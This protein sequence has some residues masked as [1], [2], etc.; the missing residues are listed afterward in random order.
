MSWAPPV[1]SGFGNNG[2][3]SIAG[4]APR[5]GEDPVV[6]SNFV[7]PGYFQT[8]GQRLLAGRDFTDR[9]RRGAPRVAIINQSMA[10]YFFGEESP[11]GH[12][13]A[14]W[15]GKTSPPDCEI[16]GIVA[17]A[18]HFDLKEPPKRVVYVPYD[19]GPDF[20]Q[21]ENMVL[22]V[23]ST[24]PPAL[25]T[26]HARELVARID[27]SVLVESETLET[28]VNG[29]IARE[30]LL[31]LLSG[32]LGLLSLLLAAMGLYGVMAYSVTCRTAE[33]GIRLALGARPAAVLSMVL[34]EGVVLVLTGVAIGL[35]AALGLSRVLAALLF[36]VSPRDAV[37]FAGAV[38]VLAIVA[39]LAT[40][41]P[42][43]RAAQIEPT[44]ALRHE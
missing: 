31:A 5:P 41:L 33:I 8:I 43:R 9:D 40:L 44:L 36:G 23:R 14:P 4:R 37:A 11:I 30:R 35:V 13:I 7:S 26:A 20:L 18:A 29:S 3:L 17:D 1:S 38:C 15:D 28:H 6:W 27:K 2:T 22:A 24:S 16:I 39:V 34:R 10:R 19:Q 32:F 42:A 21:G 25:V 12:L